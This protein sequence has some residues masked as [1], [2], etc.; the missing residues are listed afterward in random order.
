MAKNDKALQDAREVLRIEAEA[1]MALSERID[2]AFSAVVEMILG[3]KGKIVTSGLGKSGLVA[4]KFASTMAST[5]TPAVFMHPV[6]ALHG[7]LGIVSRDDLLVLIS[8][9]GEND[10]ILNLL[11]AA[12][13]IG[14]KCLSMTG[15]PDST[16]GRNAD[17]SLNVGV[18]REACPLGLVPTASTTAAMAMGDAIA[19]ALMKH[20]DFRRE[21][22]AVFHPG[23]SLGQRLSLK[24]SDIMLSGADVPSIRQDQTLTETLRVMSEVGN[25]GVVFVVDEDGRLC[26][27][28]TDGDIR[29]TIRNNAQWPSTEPI[30]KY[31]TPAPKTVEADV[32]ASEALRIMEAKGITSL[33][34]VDGEGFPVGIIHL[35]DILGRGKFAV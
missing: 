30:S 12:K 26:G 9:S 16:L 3:T 18:E 4:R 22:F 34:I 2:G 7:D 24:V 14:A 20:R 31:M 10:E 8:N 21:D 29:R 11:A 32:P 23:G 28:Y 15:D 1:V 25:L 35:H 33:A 19:V 17:I 27:V 13:K 5:G 6:D